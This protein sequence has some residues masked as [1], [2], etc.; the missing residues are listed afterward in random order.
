MDWL[1][2]KF[3]RL[4]IR[5][6]YVFAGALVFLIVVALGWSF[7]GTF[8][9]EPADELPQ[10]DDDKEHFICRECGHEIALPLK[11]VVRLREQLPSE[12]QMLILDCKSCNTENSKLV[13]T[14]CPSCRKYYLSP[15]TVARAREGGGYVRPEELPADVCTHCGTNR[16]EWMSE[17]V[18]K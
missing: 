13:A 12:N 16:T 6:D 17:N 7:Y 11:E 14:W 1:W 5:G 2:D 15:Q 4:G 3:D 9:T 8:F 18:I 10:P